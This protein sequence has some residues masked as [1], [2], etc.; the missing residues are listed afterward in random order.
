MFS[1]IKRQ[2]VSIEAT[3]FQ[4]LTDDQLDTVIGGVGNV[5]VNP[6]IIRDVSNVANG[7]TIANVVGN[8]IAPSVPVTPPASIVVTG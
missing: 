1:K 4:E 7:N 8:T 5:T 3:E 6:R 2:P